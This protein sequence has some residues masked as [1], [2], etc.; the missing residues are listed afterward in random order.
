MDL[1][2]HPTL[3]RHTAGMSCSWTGGAVEPTIVGSHP[4]EKLPVRRQPV[5][6]APNG[7]P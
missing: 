6:V 2:P 1:Q 7:L 4:K 5:N 3:R